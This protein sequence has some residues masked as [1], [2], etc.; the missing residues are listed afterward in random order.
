MSQFNTPM[1]RAG[2][3]L[4]IYT[5][6]L[7]VAFIMLLGGILLLARANSNHSAV[8]NQSGGMLKLVDGSAA[9]RR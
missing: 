4:D 3:D 7:V 2:G 1:R 5:G 6:L 9:P 8:G